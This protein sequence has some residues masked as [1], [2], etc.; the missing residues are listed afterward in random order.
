[1]VSHTADLN[2]E[3]QAFCA[4]MAA[5]PPK[6]WP[7]DAREIVSEVLCRYDGPDEAWPWNR[8]RPFPAP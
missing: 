4:N 2:A 5:Q 7:A 3:M 8:N 6:D 1:M